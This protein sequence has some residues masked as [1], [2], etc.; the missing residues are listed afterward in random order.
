MDVKTTFLNGYLEED[1]YM[2]QSMDF[3]YDDG[4]HRVCKMQRSIYGLKQTSQSW[5]YHFDKVTKSFDFIKNEEEPY[6]YNILRIV[7]G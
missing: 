6:V 1:I 4:D 5:N 7:H 3:T 2:E